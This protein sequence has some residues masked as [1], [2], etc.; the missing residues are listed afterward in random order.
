MRSRP[1]IQDRKE[2]LEAKKRRVRNII[3]ILDQAYPD[4]TLALQFSTPLELLIALILAAQCTDEL[5]NTVTAKLFKKYRT[6]QKWARID[7]DTLEQEIRPITFFRNKTKSIQACC[8]ELINRFDS[9]VPESLEDLLTL[10]G[11][12]RKTA[13]ILRGNAFSQAAIGV[14]RHVG[15]LSQLMGLTKETNPDKIEFDL[16]PLV[17]EDRKV[18]FCHLLQRHGRSICLAR[19]PQCTGCP[20]KKLCPYAEKAPFTEPKG[21]IK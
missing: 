20:V 1:K 19:K 7:R 15:R 2:T 12:G 14:D 5:V 18:R 16:N 3:K 11:V 17:P 6:P 21:K 9:N 8:L 10:P 4:T 13:N